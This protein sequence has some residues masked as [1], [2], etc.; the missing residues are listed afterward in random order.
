MTPKQQ[1]QSL[2]ESLQLLAAPAE[3]QLSILPNFVIATDEIATTFGDSYL[4]VPQ[5]VRHGY[6]GV[7]AADQLAKLDSWFV[8]LPNDGSISDPESLK[9]HEFWAS[10]RILATETL[11]LLNEE[12]RPPDLSNIN[13]VE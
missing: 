5:L 2:I 10:A 13:W 12:L 1:L 3:L 8:D 9:S 6:I 11:K 4:L 7:D